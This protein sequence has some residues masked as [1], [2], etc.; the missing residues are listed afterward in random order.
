MPIRDSLTKVNKTPKA[1]LMW[2]LLLEALFAL[3]LGGFIVWWTWP[4]G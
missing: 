1:K 4:R 2:I 3:L